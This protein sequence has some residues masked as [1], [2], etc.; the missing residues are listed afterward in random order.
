MNVHTSS[1]SLI[2]ISYILE[3]AYLGIYFVYYNVNFQEYLAMSWYWP[4]K[5]RFKRRF[6]W[7]LRCKKA[8]SNFLNFAFVTLAGS[9]NLDELHS[10]KHYLGTTVR[11]KGNTNV[12]KEVRQQLHMYFV[13]NSYIIDHYSEKT[14]ILIRIF[15]GAAGW[16]I[17]DAF[18]ME[19]SVHRPPF[20]SNRRV[21]S[22]TTFS[23]SRFSV[24]F[25][26]LLCV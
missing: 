14:A 20:I 8:I 12:V 16:T 11:I 24:Q 23:I 1:N 19:R 13:W 4:V 18:W 2:P 3:N 17:W 6:N 10:H 7:H 5:P 9:S 22:S 25:G 26:Y 21:K 15:S